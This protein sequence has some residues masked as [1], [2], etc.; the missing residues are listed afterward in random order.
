MASIAPLIAASMLAL[1]EP[2]STPGPSSMQNPAEPLPAEPIIG[3]EQTGEFEYGAI[4]AILTSH[5]GLCTGTVVTPRLILTAA[6]CI[7]GL[8]PLGGVDVHYGHDLY[9]NTPVDAVAYGAHPD[10][11]PEGRE[12]IYDYAYVL[13]GTDFSPPDGFLPPITEQDEWDEAIREGATI[14]L[15]GFGEDPDANNPVASLGVKRKVDTTIT[16]FS[17][18]GLEF[19]AGGDG[20]DSCQGDSGGPAIVRL[21]GGGARLA[22]ITSRG[23]DPCGDGGFYGAPFPALAWIRDETGIDLLPADCEDGECLDM[24]PPAE[25]EGRCA[26]GASERTPPPW[27]LM[28]LALGLVRRRRAR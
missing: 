22:G 15:V 25:K 28:L 11:D 23:S 24:S 1:A 9:A 10:F 5:S 16:R 6:H 20:H 8:P 2:G 7:V 26:V 4:V 27:S 12:D 18:L 21:A 19:F 3:G 14:T 13:L 17:E